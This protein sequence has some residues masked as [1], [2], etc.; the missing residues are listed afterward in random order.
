[1]SDGHMALTPGL[2]SRVHRI[3]EDSGPLP[4]VVYHTD[5]DYDAAV[6]EILASHWRAED[7][8]LFAYGSLIWRPEIEHIEERIGTAHGWHRSF[9]LRL[10]R[11]RGTREQPGLMMALDRGGQCKG[12]VYR[13]VRHNVEAQLGKLFRREMS[14]KPSTNMPR[15]IPVETDEGH[16]RAVAFVA[17]RSGT[18]YAGRLTPEET[19]N[20]LSKACGHW[21]TCA[22]YLYNTVFHLEERGIHDRNLW[23]LQQLVADRIASDHVADF[24]LAM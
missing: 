13:L 5:E 2:V 7:L 11:W 21:G 17:N 19:A 23:R 8:W 24:E 22:E 12:L 20:V 16:V 3:V 14:V 10:V 15:W 1:M 9:C 18:A 6:Q 4:G